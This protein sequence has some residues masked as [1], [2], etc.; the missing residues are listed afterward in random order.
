MRVLRPDGAATCGL[1]RA[2]KC[3]I[4][5]AVYYERRDF[6]LTGRLFFAR[7]APAGSGTV[8]GYPKTVAHCL[9]RA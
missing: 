4:G 7:A 6:S 9:D 5:A 1:L 2:R 3:E 8:T